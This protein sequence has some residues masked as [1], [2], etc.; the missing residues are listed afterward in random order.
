MRCRCPSCHAE[1]SLEQAAA[2]EAARELMALL[3]EAPAELGRPLTAYLGLFRARSRALA[4]E[5]ALRLAREVAALHADPFVLGEAL[6]ETVDALRA[7]QQ[8]GSWKPLGNHNY[9]RRVLESVAARPRPIA[10]S[11]SAS[12]TAPVSRTR[13]AVQRL[14]E[15]RGD[16][17]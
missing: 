5:R 4:W 13:A 9:L 15:G 3:A 1:F 11:P 6:S 16:G 12:A 8:E 10:A 14:L 17:R 7:K 2:D